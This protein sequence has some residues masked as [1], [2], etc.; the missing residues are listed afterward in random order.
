[1]LKHT[2]TKT[3]ET[4]RLI[5]RQFKEKDAADMFNNWASDDEVTRY[6]SWQTHSD[7]EVSK[8]TLKMWI[9][10]Y[11]NRENYNWAIEIKENG[12]VVGSIVIFNIDNNIEN[13]EIGYC[14]SKAFWNK[15][16]TT[17][18]FSAVINFAF[19]EVGFE[20]IT[21]RHNV[22]NLASGR[23]MEKCGL[24]Y[25][26]TLRKIHRMNTGSLVDC[27][28]YSILKGEYVK[29][30]TERLSVLP[31]DKYNLELCI[32]NYNKMERNLGLAI[33][34]KNIGIKEENVYKIRLKDVQNNPLNFM[35]YTTWII[36]LNGENRSI[37]AIMVKGYPNEDGEVVVGYAMQSD[38]RR[39]GYML[40][41]LNS[42]IQWMFL[43]S[44]VK[45][46][47]ADTL[48]NNIPSHKLLQK[49]GMVRYKEDDECI[50]WKLKK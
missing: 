36:I 34:N 15:G 17:E 44:K 25:E 38:Y 14:T 46:V 45:C 49:L 2:G 39:K 5:L 10:E 26:G 11:S 18:A 23:V 4:Q 3:I 7:I 48:K 24:K 12:S 33:T 1:M 47:I 30:N 9:D 43:N 21:G 19:K 20:R 13:C 50:W 32:N 16:I 40:E 8:K 35:W 22:D 28:Y 29:L 27:K 6:V 42:I 41:A 31:L 37:G